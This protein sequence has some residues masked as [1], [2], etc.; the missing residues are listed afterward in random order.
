[1][2]LSEGAVR[3]VFQGFWIRGFAIAALTL[4]VACGPAKVRNP[5]PD[6]KVNAAQPFGREGFRFWGDTVTARDIEQLEATFRPIYKREFGA[7]IAAGR[8][9][10]LHFLALSGGG[11][12]G[13]FGAGVLRGWSESGERPVFR[14]VSGISTGAIIAPFAFLGSDYDDTLREIYTTYSTDDLVEPTV[15]SGVLTGTALAATDKLGK[16]IARYMTPELLG[17]IAA[18]HRDGRRL[19]IGT[20]NLD[21]GR[22]V[23][24]DVG[25]IAASGEPGALDLVRSLIRASASIPVAFPPIFVDVETPDGEVY[26]EMHVDGGASSQ[27]TFISPEVP[28]AE[29]TRRILGRNLDRRLYVIVN[30]DLEPPHKAIPARIT[31]IGGAAVSSLIRSSGTGDTYRLFAIAQRD[32][33]KFH[34]GWIPGEV[35]CPE[36]TEDFDKVFMQCLFDVGSKTYLSGDLWR[37][38]P[39]FFRVPEEYRR[40]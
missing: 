3:Q 40:Q 19:L 22:P 13:A 12:W 28:I 34:V 8:T 20:T 38:K 5:V 27:V 21:A 24:W 33:L 25:A 9:P 15:V 7:D 11:Q 37:N 29:L 14:G 39:P 18:A 35:P 6:D 17:E 16:M 30:N 31:D 32:E 36:P 26:D 4:V 1:M 10:V 23:I 2:R